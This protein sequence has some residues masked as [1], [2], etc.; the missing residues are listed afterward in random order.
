MLK[1]FSTILIIIFVLFIG[2]ALGYYILEG[3]DFFDSFYMT[4]ITLSTT[5]F[6][7]IKPLSSFGRI[8]TM[9]LIFTG[10]S[11]LFYTIGKLNTIIFEGDI[12]RGRKMQKRIYELYQFQKMIGDV[13]T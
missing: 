13:Q 10:V 12:I 9:I 1:E 5:G 8:F 6:Q 2:G 3:W 4:V 11:V 7:E